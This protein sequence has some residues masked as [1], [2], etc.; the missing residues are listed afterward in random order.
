[1]VI[2]FPYINSYMVF[3]QTDPPYNIL[4]FG[5]IPLCHHTRI[6]SDVFTQ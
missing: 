2:V 4:S 5:R 1:M 3:G 6:E